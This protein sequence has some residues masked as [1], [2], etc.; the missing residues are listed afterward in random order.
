MV[1]NEK[2]SSQLFRRKYDIFKHHAWAGTV[3]LSILLTFRY[4]VKSFPASIFTLLFLIIA[5][6]IL[7]A[8]F[9]TY[10][11]RKGLYGKRESAGIVQFE[12]RIRSKIEKNR[13]KIAK[14]EAKAEAKIRKKSY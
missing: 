11:F 4:V 8:L 2:E 9:L 5:V 14:K 6:Y 12:N 3:L 13:I 7:I 1:A 10:R